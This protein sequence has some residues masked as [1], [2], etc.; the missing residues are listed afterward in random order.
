MSE[1]RVSNNGWNVESALFRAF[2]YICR[3]CSIAID[4]EGRVIIGLQVKV[5][6]FMTDSA[7]R[8]V[9]IFSI[10]I[11]TGITSDRGVVVS[12]EVV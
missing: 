1:S 9:C 8:S 6:L 2:I 11:V 7:L 12:N 5:V 4:V 10:L 3:V